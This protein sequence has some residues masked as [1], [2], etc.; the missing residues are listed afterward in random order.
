[1]SQT[2]FRLFH[3]PTATTILFQPIEDGHLAGQVSVQESCKANGSWGTVTVSPDAARRIWAA[4]KTLGAFD[5][6]KHEVI[7]GRIYKREAD[8]TISYTVIVSL[9]DH[10][11]H[12][13]EYLPTG[14]EYVR[15]SYPPRD[16]DLDHDEDLAAYHYAKAA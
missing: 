8:G 4:W 14:Y 1:M 12:A 3:R 9:Y 6:R 5:L 16:A 7:D 2:S 10:N 13:D 11:S 15:C